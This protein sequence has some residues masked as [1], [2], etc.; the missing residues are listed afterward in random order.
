MPPAPVA[1]QNLA[2][3]GLST[4]APV[5][6]LAGRRAGRGANAAEDRVREF[7]ALSFSGRR[8]PARRAGRGSAARRRGTRGHCPGMG[9]RAGRTRE[10]AS[11]Y[12]GIDNT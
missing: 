11:L 3:F 12:P 9:L 8:G 1:G 5:G 2:Y 4:L 7:P 6:R 10:G